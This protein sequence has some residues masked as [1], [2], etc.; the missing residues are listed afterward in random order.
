MVERIDEDL[1]DRLEEST[2]TE[3]MEDLS[4]FWIDIGGEG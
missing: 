4:H 1:E 2:E 3:D